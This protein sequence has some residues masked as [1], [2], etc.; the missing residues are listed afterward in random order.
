MPSSKVRTIFKLPHS[1]LRVMSKE[2][3]LPGGKLSTI[4]FL[5][6]PGAV[7]IIPF[8]QENKI[9]LLKQ[10]RPVIGKYLYELPAGTL[11]PKESLLSCA[12]RELIEETGYS[13]SR[14]KRI[15][16]IYPV[17]GY[18]TEEIIFYKAEGLK[19]CLASPEDDE[20][21]HVFTADRKQVG[22]LFRKAKMQDAKTISAFALCGWL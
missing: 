21:I 22:D 5:R 15:G 3:R 18:S 16:S 14:V 1:H 20:V 4:E 13:A 2:A 12:R 7:L 17:P 11:K 8:L 10:F 6:H 19:K 9:V